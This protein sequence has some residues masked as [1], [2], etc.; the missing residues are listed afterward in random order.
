MARYLVTGGA[1]FIGSHI[2]ER[3]ARDGHSVR[4]LDNLSTGR[5]SNV[6]AVQAIAPKGG[7]EWVEGDVRSIE[8]CRSACEGVEFVIH[9][10]ALPSVQ[11]SIENPAETNEVNVGGFVN[12][13]TAARERRVRRVV[14]ASSSSV[15]GDT[16]TLPKAEEMATTPLSPYAASKVAAECYARVFSKTMGLSTVSL[17]YFNVFGPR[18]DPLSP[19]AAVI[20][21]FIEALLD[22]RRPTVYGDGEQS[23]DF[24]YVE[25]VVT[26]NLLAC[27]RGEGAGEAL[28]IAGGTQRSLLDLLTALGGALGTTPDPQFLPRRSGDVMHSYADIRA[29]KERL[30]Y[31]PMVGLEEGLARTVEH[32][33]RERS[34]GRVGT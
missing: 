16:P 27:A 5:R 10:A 8:A 19:Y 34:A 24:T 33:R 7:F 13:L 18:Q 15:Y 26:A 1:G 25:N 11:R 29:A 6:D 2:A 22:G 12:L 32:H 31:I 17:R 3:L 9:Q 23:R 4:V 21:A 28:N 20:P 14:A 30:G